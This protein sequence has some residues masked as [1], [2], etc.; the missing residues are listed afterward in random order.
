MIQDVEKEMQGYNARIDKMET[1]QKAIEEKMQKQSSNSSSPIPNPDGEGSGHQ[2]INLRLKAIE[3]ELQNLKFDTSEELLLKKKTMLMKGFEACIEVTEQDASD[4][5]STQLKRLN[6]P[7]QN[8]YCKGDFGNMM[9]IEFASEQERDQ[10]VRK[11][12]KEQIE[13]Q[14]VSNLQ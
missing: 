14:R 5:I 9:W 12:R 10:A 11:K 2:S 8:I 3:K 6:I 7:Y 13:I 1:R 4:W